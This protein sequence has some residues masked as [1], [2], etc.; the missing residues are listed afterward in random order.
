ML[1]KAVSTVVPDSGKRAIDSVRARS[2]LRR[3]GPLNDEYVRRSGLE[4]RRGPF[5][6]MRY[7]S[8][9]EHVSGHLIAKLAGTYERQIY[10][11]LAEWVA[12]Q[13]ELVI[14]VGCAEGFYA[15]G[16]ARAIPRVNVHAYDID[17][18][19]RGYCAELARINDVQD[20]VAIRGLCTPSTL[21]EVSAVR[22]VLL[23]DC[24]GYEKT[25]LD[26]EIATNLRD[27]SIVV[28][29][30]DN[31]DPAISTTIEARFGETHEIELVEYAHP[32]RDGL[33]ELDW[34]SD[35]Q[36][37]LVLHERPLPMSWAFLRPRSTS[38]T[39]AK[40]AVPTRK[41]D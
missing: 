4:I 3:V 33:P 41:N 16:L 36:A 13:P 6:G 15:V 8:G 14:D 32:E 35:K 21:A 19:A 23:S 17:E 7:L 27:W 5:A 1:R 28:E 31:V 40:T 34:M 37:Q 38:A 25:L 22:V 30:H 26:P 11:W 39:R 20:R 18:R 10:P 9:Q 29:L 12:Y 24:E 2:F